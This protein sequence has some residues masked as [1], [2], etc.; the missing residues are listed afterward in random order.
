MK[1]RQIYFVNSYIII[2]WKLLLIEKNFQWQNC[3]EF[4][5]QQLCNWKFCSKINSFQD[6][7]YR[8]IYFL[9]FDIIISWKLLLIEKNFQSQSCSEFDVQ[10]L[11]NW[12]FCSKINSFKDMKYRQFYFIN[13]DIII[14]WKQL[15]I[16]K[17]FQLQSCSKFDVQR[18]FNWKFCSDI[19]SFQNMMISKFTKPI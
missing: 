4:D 19:N 9:N 10:Q 3:S 8:Q 18:L 13:F 15:L 14:S 11:C 1:Y 5:V 2:S 6:M 7:K 17:N 12:K 16:E